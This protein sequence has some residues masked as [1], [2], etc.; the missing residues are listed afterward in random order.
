MEGVPALVS[1]IYGLKSQ[2]AD[3][4]SSMEKVHTTSRKPFSFGGGGIGSA[5]GGFG[6]PTAIGAGSVTAVIAGAVKAAADIEGGM[7][8]VRQTT[9]LQGKDLKELE[10]GLLDIG[11]NRTGILNK[12]LMAIAANAGQ[13][14]IEGKANIL[15]FTDTIARM[16]AISDTSAEETADNFAQLLN[17]FKLAPKDA[18]KLG[19]SMAQLAVESVATAG[20][21]ADLT[22][23]IGGAG[24]TLGMTAPQVMALSATLRDAGVHVEVGGTSISQLLMK[25]ATAPE[26]FAKV[27][28]M[29]AHEFKTL[30]RA[31]PLTAFRTVIVEMAK[32]GKDGAEALNGMGLDGVRTTGTIMQ[33]AQVTEKLDK[34]IATGARAWEENNSLMQQY[35]AQAQGAWKETDRL[36]NSLQRLGSASSQTLL[37]G[38]K[39]AMGGITG[40]ATDQAK[41]FEDGAKLKAFVESGGPKKARDRIG[42]LESAIG[43]EDDP[44][45][46]LA[47]R[48]QLAALMRDYKEYLVSVDDEM[49]RANA[50]W[51]TRSGASVAAGAA[52][53]E[54][55][56]QLNAMDAFN[57]RNIATLESRLG[58]DP[59]EGGDAGKFFGGVAKE[60]SNFFTRSGRKV[61]DRFKALTDLVDAIS[62]ETMPE[63]A[64]KNRAALLA[65]KTSADVVEVIGD[66]MRFAVAGHAKSLM[67]TA[68]NEKRIGDDWDEFQKGVEKDEKEARDKTKDTN[69]MALRLDEIRGI[70][71]KRD[72]RAATMGL[73]D[74]FRTVQEAALSGGTMSVEEG[75]KKLVEKQQASADSLDAI[76]RL[77][78]EG[79]ANF[80]DGA[81]ILKD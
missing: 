61:E 68:R 26:A 1:G 7:A 66:V 69:A 18:E 45:K 37:G 12:D 5:M 55:R 9:G 60:V 34:N 28:R 30:M 62:T 51:A 52:V 38:A 23:R 47:M 32:L 77:I 58:I 29:S 73:S 75:V 80:L 33:L 65:A 15:A 31:D 57:A 39:G 19:S 67:E 78:D 56:A 36:W 14:G 48:K 72:F 27:A 49:E 22:K 21:I 54:Q 3:L 2:F 43:S 74:R 24:A 50:N 35:T 10:A 42:T 71:G 53:K 16:A 25:M 8:R 44:G 63:A 64:Q 6:L 40:A 41:F 4:N 46:K 59:S 81:L 17:I 13:L 20:Q 11:T 79:K 70:G 76:K